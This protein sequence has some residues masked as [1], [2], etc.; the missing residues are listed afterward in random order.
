[1]TVFSYVIEHDLGFAPNPFHRFCTLACCKPRIRSVAT[2]GDYILGTGACRPS[3]SGH[4]IYWMRVDEV[5][6]FDEYWAD[7]RFK[8]KKPI[9]A[10]RCLSPLVTRFPYRRRTAKRLAGASGLRQP[11]GVLLSVGYALWWGNDQLFAAHLHR[12]S[13]D[14]LTRA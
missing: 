4:L 9:M 14:E 6:T 13:A 3:L 5:L 8:K 7:K 11:R 2:L 10:K 1:M 12:G